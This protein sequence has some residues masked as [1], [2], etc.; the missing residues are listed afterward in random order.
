MVSKAVLRTPTIRGRGRRLLPGDVVAIIPYVEN[1]K[2][3][4]FEP[5]IPCVRWAVVVECEGWGK[6]RWRRNGG[7]AVR[8]VAAAVVRA[9]ERRRAVK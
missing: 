7:A 1:G 5:A 2:P 4:S 3:T 9:V 6:R 8:V